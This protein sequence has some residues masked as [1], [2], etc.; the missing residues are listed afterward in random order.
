MAGARKGIDMTTEAFPLYWPEGRTRTDRSRR[1]RARFKTTFATAR[2]ELLNELRR[3]G[4]RN[5]VLSTNIPLRN[6]GLPYASAK[7]PEDPGTAVYFTYKKNQMCFACDRWDRVQDNVQAINHTIAALRGVARWGTGD[8]MEAAFKGF[9]ALPAP[10]TVWSSSWRSILNFGET[11]K[12]SPE[13]LVKRWRKMRSLNH[14]D[15]NGHPGAFAA[16]KDAYEK[17]CAELGITP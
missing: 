16:V 11:E 10:A 6:D 4:A 15:N 5:V 14:P 13:D 7:P 17:G 1:E 2:D 12:I 8:M 3:L 9:T